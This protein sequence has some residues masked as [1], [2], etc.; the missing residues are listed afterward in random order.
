M[1]RRIRLVF[2]LVGIL[3]G[4]LLAYTTRH[5]V[6]SDA[7]AYAEMG[8]IFINGNMWGLVNFTFSS[9]FSVLTGLLQLA[10]WTTPTNEILVLKVA[11]YATYLMAL[12]SCDLLMSVI[13]D[14]WNDE[15]T[16][17]FARLTFSLA[18]ALCYTMFLVA[19]LVWVR[20]RLINPDMLIVVFALL[21]VACVLRIREEPYRYSRYV[22]LGIL[23]GLGYLSK[24][25]F[26]AYSPFLFILTVFVS[27]D[28]KK[29]LARII[30]AVAA[31]MIVIFWTGF[32]K[33]I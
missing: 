32:V 14:Q 26:F 13:R 8:E 22:M 27:P 16:S 15:S 1:F 12:G 21:S 6:N 30:C 18:S 24:A 7:L 3:L 10:P 19:A 11:N 28:Y 17:R 25:V 33:S 20:V 29:S 2:W 5:Y 4:A 9:I 31:Y 23:C